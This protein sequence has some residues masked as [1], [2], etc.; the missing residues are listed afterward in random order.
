M[1]VR[2]LLYAAVVAAAALFVQPQIVLAASS[3]AISPSVGVYGYAFGLPTVAEAREHALQECA[4]HA[5]DC[6]EMSSSEQPGYLAVARGDHGVAVTQGQESAEAAQRVALEGCLQRYQHCVI[7][8]LAI[9]AYGL[10][11][12]GHPAPI[13]ETLAATSR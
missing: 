11:P 6:R 4:R 2:R 1:L 12:A 7:D 8:R 5:S 3:I 10:A 13:S 9:D